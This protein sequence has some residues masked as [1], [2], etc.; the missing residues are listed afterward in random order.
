VTLTTE[1]KLHQFRLNEFKPSGKRG[2]GDR[3]RPGRISSFTIEGNGSSSQ[4]LE[5]QFDTLRVEAR[6]Q[7]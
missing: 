6:A 4:I 1:W 7:K 3:A 5:L 2:Q